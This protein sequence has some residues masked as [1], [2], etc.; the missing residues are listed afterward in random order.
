MEISGA[1]AFVTGGSGDLGARVCRLLA[2]E[3]VS[4]TIGYKQGK[5]RAEEI[6]EQIQAIDGSAIAVQVDQLSQTSISLTNA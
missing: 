6:S 2:D 3:G 4:I 1:V 5:E